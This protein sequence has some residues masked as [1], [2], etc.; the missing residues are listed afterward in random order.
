MPSIC[1]VAF[2]IFPVVKSLVSQATKIFFLI[3]GKFETDPVSVQCLK[4]S[5]S[6]LAGEIICSSLA[7]DTVFFS[8][9]KMNNKL[10]RI[11]ALRYVKTVTVTMLSKQDSSPWFFCFQKCEGLTKRKK[12]Q[13]ILTANIT[14]CWVCSVLGCFGWWRLVGGWCFVDRHKSRI[15]N[16]TGVKIKATWF[17]QD[18]VYLQNWNVISL[19]RRSV[20]SLTRETDRT[21]DTAITMFSEYNSSTKKQHPISKSSFVHTAGACLTLERLLMCLQCQKSVT[22][23]SLTM[24]CMN[25]HPLASWRFTTPLCPM[26]YPFDTLSVDGVKRE[27]LIS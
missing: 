25:L 14:W 2:S 7:A 4:K 26:A 23:A 8:L 3:Q 20:Y 13:L 27:T 10:D 11:M 22:E 12:H 24:L 9:S 21:V 1:S 6:S 5:D 18:G 15:M 16:L 19:T 17:K